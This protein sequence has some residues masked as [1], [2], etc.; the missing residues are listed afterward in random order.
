[1]LDISKEEQNIIGILTRTYIQGKRDGLGLA[2]EYV[3]MAQDESISLEYCQ[4][5][6][7]ALYENFAM[8][9]RSQQSQS[10]ETQ[11]DPEREVVVEQ[12]CDRV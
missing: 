7:V 1:M 9:L 2:A 4:Q 11:F 5:I 6:I 3:E 8:P 12:E 10:T